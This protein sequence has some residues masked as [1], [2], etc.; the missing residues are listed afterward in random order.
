MLCHKVTQNASHNYSKTIKNVIWRKQK[1]SLHFQNIFHG[2]GRKKSNLFDLPLF[3]TN[4]LQQKKNS[5]FEKTETKIFT[6]DLMRKQKK[7]A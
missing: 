7:N 2:H 5:C 3:F 6:K 1:R 4:Q